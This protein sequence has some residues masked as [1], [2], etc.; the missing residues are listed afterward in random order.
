MKYRQCRLEKKTKSGKLCQTSYIPEKYAFVG[1]ILKL[2]EEDGN[3]VNGWKVISAGE[4]R[5][6]TPDFHKD[7]KGHR[8]ATGDSLPK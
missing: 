5:E 2:R 7:I 6:E 4:L 1:N 8:K 3:W